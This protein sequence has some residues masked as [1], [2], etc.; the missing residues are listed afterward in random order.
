VG[1]GLEVLIAGEL[2]DEHVVD[3][4]R[5]FRERYAQVFVAG[6]KA[7]AGAR[8]TLAELSRRGYRLAVASNK[9]ARF[10]EPLLDSLGMLAVLDSVQGPDRAGSTKPDPAMIHACLADM[11]LDAGTALYVGDM[12]LDVESGRRAGVA[13]VLVRGG[14]SS[15]AELAAAG[16]PVLESLTD[17]LELLGPPARS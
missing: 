15:S 10:S 4:V 2:G 5:R 1:H 8:E 12:A 7:L 13:V 9:P 3:G 17:L 6:T 16:R 14:S 11:G